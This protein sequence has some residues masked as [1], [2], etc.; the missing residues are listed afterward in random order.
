M[1]GNFVLIHEIAQSKEMKERMSHPIFVTLGA[2]LP[3]GQE[4]TKLKPC[5][6]SKRATGNQHGT[7]F[8]SAQTDGVWFPLAG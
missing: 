5:A 7:V 6:K 1:I 8:D 2:R 3:D 4:A